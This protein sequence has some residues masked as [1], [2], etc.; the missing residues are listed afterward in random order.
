M[1]NSE[2]F[3]LIVPQPEHEQA[4][5]NYIAEYYR[6]REVTDR[7]VFLSKDAFKLYGSGGL[8]CYA[9]DYTSWLEKLTTDRN[10]ATDAENVPTETYFL[11]RETIARHGAKNVLPKEDFVG[12]VNIRLSMN[13]AYWGHDGSI[14]YNIRPDM[15]GNGYSKINLFLAL[16]ICQKHGFESVLL[17]CNKT[18]FASAATI[19]ALGGRLV[20]EKHFSERQYILQ[21]YMID[22]DRAIAE[23]ET[24]YVKYVV[25]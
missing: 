8:F 19:R 10:R 23:H 4:V 18:N 1:G 16:C 13:D 20:R 14:G 2:K 12:M 21:Y 6:S 24:E 9:K 17:T 11:V 22:V 7:A 3:R 15:R 25:R 5:K